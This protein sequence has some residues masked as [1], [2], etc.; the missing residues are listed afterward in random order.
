MLTSGQIAHFETFGFV[1]LR[2]VFSP[3]ETQTI[4]RAYDEAWEE[5][6][7]GRSFNGEWTESLSKFCD[8]SALLTD[9]AE[10]DRVYGPVE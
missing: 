9:L 4:K 7:G 6:L 10:D 8:G 2:Q 5:A 3:N 1:I